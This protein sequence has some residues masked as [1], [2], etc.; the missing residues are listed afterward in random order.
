[1][2]SKVVDNL[3]HE[4]ILNTRE[5]EQFC[6]Q[7]FGRYLH[8]TPMDSAQYSVK[9]KKYF[10]KMQK[11]MQNGMKIIWLYSCQQEKINPLNPDSLPLLF[12]IDEQLNTANGFTYDLKKCGKDWGE[13]EAGCGG[14]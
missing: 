7:A 8:H 10:R 12:V 5:Y 9:S 1:M 4:F 13:V 11:I 6:Q 3:W 14:G 2:P